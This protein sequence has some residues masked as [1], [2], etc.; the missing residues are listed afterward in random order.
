MISLLKRILKFFRYMNARPQPQII[1]GGVIIIGSLYWED[2]NNCVQ[3]QEAKGLIRKNWR[4]N[5]LDLSRRS[6]IQLPVR[7][8]RF[9]NRAN[10]RETYTMILSQQYNTSANLGTGLI[11]P[12]AK[13]IL[14]TC[15]F[16]AQADELANAE[17]IYREPAPVSHVADWGAI[18]IWI[19]PAS[20][21]NREVNQLW[22]QLRADPT[23]GYN[24]SVADFAWS[25]GHLLTNDY[26]LNLPKIE[27]TLDFVFC[28]YI[29]PK[30]KIAAN[31]KIGHFVYPTAKEIADA[32]RASGYQTYFWENKCS[33]IHTID[34][35]PIITDLSK[36]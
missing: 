28:T 24:K 8:G 16:K 6:Q 22:A 18:A 30:H 11:V 4:V 19:N 17:A 2:D 10:R 23:L 15:D 36:A 9:S 27:T 20:A 7:Y 31:N 25:D 33:G 35:A 21:V 34:D 1:N 29:I 12:F 3:G 13:P 5:N 32:M 14:N 26:Q